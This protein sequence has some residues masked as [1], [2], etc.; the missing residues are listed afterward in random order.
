MSEFKNVNIHTKIFCSSLRKFI[1]SNL[2]ATIDPP[3]MEVVVMVDMGFLGPGPGA[4]ERVGK[5]GSLMMTICKKCKEI[6][7]KKES[8]IMVLH[9]QLFTKKGCKIVNRKRNLGK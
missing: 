3:D 1:A 5:C 9:T 2:P 6:P 4:Q 7:R 8:S